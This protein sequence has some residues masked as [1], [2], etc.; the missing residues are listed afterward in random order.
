MDNILRA[1]LPLKPPGLISNWLKG[2]PSENRAN[3]WI[4]WDGLWNLDI[5]FV[6]IPFDGLS[7]VRTGSR[8]GPDAVRRQLSNYTVHSVTDNRTM[9]NLRVAD[10]GDVDILVSDYRRTFANISEIVRFLVE[11]GIKPVIFGGD[12]SIAEPSLCGIFEAMPGRRIGFIHI[13]E[14][15]DVR[16]G[17]FGSYCSGDWGRVLLEENQEQLKGRN[18]VKIGISDFC[19]NPEHTEFVKK[20]GVTVISN[21]MVWREGIQKVIE[22]ALDRA[23]DGTDAIYISID[24][25]GIDQSAAP[26]TPAPNPFGIDGRDICMAIRQFAEHPKTIGME[27]TEIVPAY[28]PDNMTSNLGAIMFLNFCYGVSLRAS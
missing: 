23:T 10:I 6:G 17:H 18:V 3:A 26:G 7:A 24:I 9:D 13:D 22:T 15:Y 5:A 25:D 8:H 16:G 20:H 28:D 11:Q 4:E 27:I 14:H 1:S 19:N 2:D 21:I 12:H